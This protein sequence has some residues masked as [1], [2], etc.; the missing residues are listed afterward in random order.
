[1]SR[2]D[3]IFK[4]L[5]GITEQKGSKPGKKKTKQQELYD[6]LES[7]DEAELNQAKK[8]VSHLIEKQEGKKQR[9]KEQYE[10]ANQSNE[11]RMDNMFKGLL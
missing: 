10:V 2:E 9:L 3:Q 8:Q 6:L 5:S 7:M 4:A 1:M 11:E